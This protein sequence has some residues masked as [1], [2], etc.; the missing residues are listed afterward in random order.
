MGIFDLC[1]FGRRSPPFQ[2]L[3][4]RPHYYNNHPG[5]QYSLVCVPLVYYSWLVFTL[6]RWAMLAGKVRLIFLAPCV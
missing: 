3:S 1:F 6:D 2:T 5:H 4:N